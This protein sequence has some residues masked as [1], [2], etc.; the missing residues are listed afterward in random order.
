MRVL[1]GNAGHRP[2]PTR[3][4][5][6]P[7]GRPSCPRI[8]TGEARKEWRRICRELESMDLM[9]A[10]DRAALVLYCQQYGLWHEASSK[11][12]QGCNAM[13]GRKGRAS[14]YLAIIRQTTTTMSKLLAEFGLTPSS[15]TRVHR[16]AVTEVA[17]DLFG[18]LN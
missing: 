9:H 13:V 2:L 4:P 3:E 11:I 14:P 10:V 1:T 8:I 6:A 15:R 18:D 7:R 5:Q 17:S 16:A 12:A